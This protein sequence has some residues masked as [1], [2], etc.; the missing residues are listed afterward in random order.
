MSKYNNHSLNSSSFL[1]LLTPKVQ[2]NFEVKHIA[3]ASVY[4]TKQ[5]KA[6]DFIDH[7][8]EAYNV[9]MSKY[10]IRDMNRSISIQFWPCHPIYFKW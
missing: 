10:H 1:A 8:C 7:I 5:T 6:K 2:T 4:Y 3:V 9:L